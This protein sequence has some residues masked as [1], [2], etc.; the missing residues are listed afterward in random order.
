MACCWQNLGRRWVRRSCGVASSVPL[1]LSRWNEAVFRPNTGGARETELF[2]PREGRR[3]GGAIPRA[4]HGAWD[5]CGGFSVCAVS[6]DRGSHVAWHAAAKN[7]CN[8]ASAFA[9]RL[10]WWMGCVSRWVATRSR[11]RSSRAWQAFAF[12]FGGP[13]G[14]S[15]S[16]RPSAARTLARMGGVGWVHAGAARMATGMR[17]WPFSWPGFGRGGGAGCG[18]PRVHGVFLIQSM[19]VRQGGFSGGR[20][21][22]LAAARFAPMSAIQ[23]LGPSAPEQTCPGSRATAAMGGDQTPATGRPEFACSP[24]RCPPHGSLVDGPGPN[25][26]NM[27]ARAQIAP[28]DA[29]DARPSRGWRDRS[30]ALLDR[31][32]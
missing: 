31:P 10:L 3:S 12:T 23:C 25:G 18:A 19:V 11:D 26:A 14:V 1:R 27:K 15:R 6:W 22:V 32:A 29:R 17:A 28:A 2:S 13:Y 21:S 7:C 4:P 20:S 9:W 30:I 8:A 24:V 16:E 5:C